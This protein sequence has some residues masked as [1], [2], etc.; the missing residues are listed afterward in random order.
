MNNELSLFSG[1]EYD[2]LFLQQF[3]KVWMIDL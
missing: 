1:Q 3:K 2:D